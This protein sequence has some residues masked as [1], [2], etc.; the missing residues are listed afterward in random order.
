VMASEVSSIYRFLREHYGDAVAV[1]MEG[2]G[3]L[4]ALHAHTSI[5]ALVIRGISDLL[6]NK[7][8]ADTAGSQ[9]LAARHA[10]GFA[11]Q[12][13]AK[14]GPENMSSPG[15]CR[16][17]TAFPSGKS[18]PIQVVNQGDAISLK[19]TTTGLVSMEQLDLIVKIAAECGL[20]STERRHLL[21]ASIPR[22]YVYSLP[23][24]ASPLDQLRSDLL[25]MSRTPTLG[26]LVE[27]PIAVWLRNAARLVQPRP[28]STFFEEIV[29]RLAG[30]SSE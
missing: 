30:G 19:A 12:V 8:V 13:L 18:S 15:L 25:E 7:L 21:F 11:F 4:S 9:E 6:A 20:A 3:F 17:G 24:L 14:L 16:D 29:Q 23:Q 22:E 10:A 26:G 2:I 28:E 1:E 27:S 5:S